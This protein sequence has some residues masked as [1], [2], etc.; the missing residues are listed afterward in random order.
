MALPIT[1]IKEISIVDYLTQRGIELKKKSGYWLCKSPIHKDTNW[2]CVIYPTNSFYDWSVGYGGSIIDLVMAMENISLGLAIKH[3]SQNNFPKIQSNYIESKKTTQ[4]D[5]EYTRYL[6]TFDEDNK[7]I[8]E[9]AKSR[10]L[11]NGYE[12]GVYYTNIDDLWYRHQALMYIHRSETGQICGVKFRNIDITSTERFSS[13]GK[14]GFYILEY[15]DKDNFGEPTLYV[16]EGEANANS[17]WQHCQ[18]IKRNCVVISFGGVGNLPDRLPLKY[19]YISE[20]KLIIDFDGNEELYYKRIRL[21]RHYV[22]VPSK[23][24]LPKGE[25]INSLY[26]KKEINLI[27]QLL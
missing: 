15:I 7:A 18:D 23:L 24:I 2:S 10:G 26:C 12:C 21:Y 11:V 5:F 1:Q 6:N 17:L 20:R 8:H 27:N 4:A 16:V 22:L 9:Y 13:R 3:L 19:D 25:D 14:M